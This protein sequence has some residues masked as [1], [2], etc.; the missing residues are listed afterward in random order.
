M[1]ASE[2][3]YATLREEILDGVLEPGTQLA[4]VEQGKRLGV[5]RT[6]V[7]E[8]LNR[9]ASDGLVQALSPRVLVVAELS[10]ERI[11][12]LY[13][14][15]RVLET[16]AA[17]L[18]A[19]RGDAEV[20]TELRARVEAAPRLLDAGEAGIAPYFEVVDALDEAIADAL[21]NPYLASALASAR[22]HSARIRR[23]ASHD[24]NRLREAAA[25]H[26][27]VVDAILA[28]DAQLAAHATHVHLHRSLNSALARSTDRKDTSA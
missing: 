11:R 19:E 27:L 17:A 5:S 21:D 6:P 10:E 24:P 28:R 22:L 20:F 12:T 9:L 26:L 4:E 7:R 3:V 15:R 18:A 23:L 14:L 8:A 13:E 1:R 2:R 16:S 25:E